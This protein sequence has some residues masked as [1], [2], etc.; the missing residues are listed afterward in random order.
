MQP[1]KVVFLE[2][3]ISKLKHCE[4]IS[5]CDS[6]QGLP[7][8]EK[9]KCFLFLEVFTVVWMTAMFLWNIVPRRCTIR[10]GR[11]VV[12]RPI[13][14]RV[15]IYWIFHDVMTGS[16]LLCSLETSTNDNPCTRKTDS[17]NMGLRLTYLSLVITLDPNL[18][19][20]EL[21]GYNPVQEGGKYITQ[22]LAWVWFPKGATFSSLSSLIRPSLRQPSLPSSEHMKMLLWKKSGLVLNLT[23]LNC[24]C[25][26]P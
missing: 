10:S 12:T 3:Q 9:K 18:T 25:T 5:F 7:D 17:T 22:L 11:F 16:A 14:S 20:A 8:W 15:L 6:I 26:C 23:A 2:G 24:N 19:K 4:V 13:S 1:N 21:A